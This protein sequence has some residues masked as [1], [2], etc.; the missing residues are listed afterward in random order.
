MKKFL[1]ILVVMALVFST[2]AL[3]VSATNSPTG[4]ITYVSEKDPVIVDKDGNEKADVDTTGTLIELTHHEE[5]KEYVPEAHEYKEVFGEKYEDFKFYGSFDIRLTEHGKK[6]VGDGK[7]HGVEITINVPGLTAANNP[8]VFYYDMAHDT[9]VIIKDIVVNGSEI[10]FEAMPLTNTDDTA[11]AASIDALAVSLLNATLAATNE[12][13]ASDTDIGHY[14]VIYTGSV[15]SPST[16]VP[17][18]AFVVI[19]V[20]ALAGA[21]FAGKKVF[22]K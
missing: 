19:L 10:T 12:F 17:T 22:A 8:T 3:A 13:V 2:M 7:L 20:V 11:K 5:D 4:K 21:A 16:G 14:G 1:S 6:E 15:T 9:Y 18:A